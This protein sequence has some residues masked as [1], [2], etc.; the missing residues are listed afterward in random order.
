M[1]LETLNTLAKGAWN[2]QVAIMESNMNSGQPLE[3]IE[4]LFLSEKL[5]RRGRDGE[6]GKADCYSELTGHQYLILIK[7]QYR[8]KHLLEIATLAPWSIFFACRTI[9]LGS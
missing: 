2:F 6:K 7:N 3:G 9:Y 4:E 8:R 1:G 5:K